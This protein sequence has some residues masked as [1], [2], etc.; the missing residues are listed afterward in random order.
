MSTQGRKYMSCVTR[1]EGASCTVEDPFSPDQIRWRVTNSS[2][3]KKRGQVLP[4]ADL[5][6]YVGNALF[7]PKKDGQQRVRVSDDQMKPNIN[8]D[9]CP[10]WAQEPQIAVRK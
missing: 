2:N 9:V 5:R 1:R 7:S 8:Q 6:A 10:Y 4:Y 3:D